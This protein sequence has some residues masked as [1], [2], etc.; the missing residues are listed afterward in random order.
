M[1]R[2]KVGKGRKAGKPAGGPVAAG[3]LAEAGL[4]DEGARKMIGVAERAV[5]GQP[6][7][8]Q[9]MKAWANEAPPGGEPE[10]TRNGFSQAMAWKAEPEWQGE[11]SEAEGET[12]GGSREPEN[13]AD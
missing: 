13:Y 2:T 12:A 7:G 11:S 6:N 5:S 8:F 4:A 3:E 1:V 10:T 9:T